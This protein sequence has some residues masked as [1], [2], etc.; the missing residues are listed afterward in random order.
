MAE[1]AK[2]KRRD[3]QRR[4]ARERVPTSAIS[5]LPFIAPPA[6]RLSS[7]K[8]LACPNIFPASVNGFFAQLA[9]HDNQKH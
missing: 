6:A 1:A 2:E 4:T 9:S 7:L 5:L 8:E 3:M